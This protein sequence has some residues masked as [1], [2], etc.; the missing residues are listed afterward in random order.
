[1][2][3]ARKTSK[4]EGRKISK[5]EGKSTNQ[6]DD[7]MEPET[8][9]QRQRRER[10]D[11]EN[12]IEGIL[13]RDRTDSELSINSIAAA[14]EEASV[15]KDERTRYQI[16]RDFAREAAS[17][18]V[19]VFIDYGPPWIKTDAEMA[20]ALIATVSNPDPKTLSLH[21]LLNRLY[22]PNIPD[23][24][25]LH[26]YA[27]HLCARNTHY[28]QM[29]MLRRAGAYIN[30]TNEMGQTPLM[31][32]VFY[33]HPPTKRPTQ[34]KAVQWLLR[35]GADPNARDKGGYTALDFAA[36]NGDEESVQ[37]ML[38][39][40]AI[41]RRENQTFVAKRKPV[42]GHTWNPKVYRV[43]H[44]KLQEVSTFAFAFAFTFTFIFRFAHT[45]LCYFLFPFMCWM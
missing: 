4:E 22:N 33:R 30:V 9:E 21:F 44:A 35:Q 14:E 10:E 13:S 12:S 31:V 1:M 43:I 24:E 25:D 16:L 42:L 39:Y 28:L 20:A 37:M 29:R 40:G 17:E 34:L 6:R 8:R 23:P 41:V 7:E 32:L 38:E 5:E 3:S 27:M 36:M 19:K 2:S 15:K 45:F 18:L 26:N 11:S